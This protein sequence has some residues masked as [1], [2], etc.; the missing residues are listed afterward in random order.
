MLVVRSCGYIEQALFEMTQL[1]IAGKS[2]GP[3]KS[4]A[5]SFVH[6]GKN[7]SPTQIADHLGRFDMMFRDEFNSLMDANDERLR[8]ELAFLVARRNQ[9]AHG[10]NEGVNMSKAREL[11]AVAEET[12]SWLILRLNPG[13]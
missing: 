7:P 5:T 11:L 9:I 10:E 3:V 12:V 2:G 13:R 6:T 8:R 1:Y 4:F